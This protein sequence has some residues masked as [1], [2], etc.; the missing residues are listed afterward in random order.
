M[1]KTEN[2]IVRNVFKEGDA[3]FNFGDSLYMDKDYFIYFHDRV[4]DTFRLSFFNVIPY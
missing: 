4:G 1:E 2:K 3:Y